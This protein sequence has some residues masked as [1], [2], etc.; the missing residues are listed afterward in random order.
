MLSVWIAA[1]SSLTT[2][3]RCGSS[4]RVRSTPPQVRPWERRPT[5]KPPLRGFARIATIERYKRIVEAQGDG[6]ATKP[7]LTAETRRHGENQNQRQTLYH[8]G[9]GEKRG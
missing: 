9:H 7:N 3:S 2:G 6:A 4:H 8:R 1:K 5:A